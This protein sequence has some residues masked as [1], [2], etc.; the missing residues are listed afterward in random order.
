MSVAISSLN[1]GSYVNHPPQHAFVAQNELSISEQKEPKKTDQEEQSKVQ[2]LKSRDREVR[3]HEQAHLSAAGAYATSGASFS[4]TKGSDGASYATGGEVSIDT[5][6]V[7]G[8]PAA[9]IR[10]ADV[11][12]RA[13]LAPASP[14]SQDQLV[15]S[16]ASAMAEKARSELIQ[17][18]QETISKTVTSHL[19]E[20]S[21]TSKK[22]S[23][24][25]FSV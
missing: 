14:S 22:G 25:D 15:A 21:D 17:K 8:D 3:T 23:H 10:K 19:I 11:I 1:Q 5:S 4:F 2:Q 20:N 12:R 18:K 6:P 24:V 9:T 16:K 7:N 13:A